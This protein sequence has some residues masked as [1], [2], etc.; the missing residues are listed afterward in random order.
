MYSKLYNIHSV[1]YRRLSYA[2]GASAGVFIV[3]LPTSYCCH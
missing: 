1:L 3:G 2:V